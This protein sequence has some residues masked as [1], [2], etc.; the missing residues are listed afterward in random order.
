M[1]SRDSDGSES[2]WI[3]FGASRFLTRD[4]MEEDEDGDNDD[5][6][7]FEVG[8]HSMQTKKPRKKEGKDSIVSP[9]DVSLYVV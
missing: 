9:W 4:E 2:L 6:D 7:A 3:S 1:T 8:V 5:D